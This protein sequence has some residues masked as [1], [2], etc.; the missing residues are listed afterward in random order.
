VSNTVR[1]DAVLL[2]TLALL[3]LL[4]QAPTAA[5]GTVTTGS[6]L[7]GTVTEAGGRTPIA[8]AQVRLVPSRPTPGVMPLMQM[9]SVITDREGRF[10]FEGVAAGRYRF[11]VQ[12]AG[13][14]TVDASREITLADGERKTDVTLSLQRGGAIAGRVLDNSGEPV[15]N[16]NVIA[17]RHPPGLPASAVQLQ[18]ILVPAGNSAQTNDL[19]EFR[20]FGLPPGEYALQV[21]SRDM[22]GPAA[23]ARRSTPVATYYPG[24]TDPIAAQMITVTAGQTLPNVDVGLI[25]LPAFQVSGVVHDRA[26]RPVMNALIR[27]TSADESRG[28]LAMMM[29]RINQAHTDA[30]GR[31]TMNSLTA[32]TYALV[33]MAPVVTSGAR[34]GRSGGASPVDFSRGGFITGVVAGS[35]GGGVTTETRGDGTTT[36]WREDT[37]TRTAVTISEADV[38]GL[39]IVISPQ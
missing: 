12:K 9:P 7:S 11:D 3:S 21:S 24:T 22:Y 2:I 10:T 16:A 38:T 19:G 17:L 15:A 23:P 26:G 8:G 18:N 25:E 34:S 28:P 14:A 39:E 27:L 13:F 30:S 20:L 35:S 36:E 37:A 4:A 32:G 33:A 6:L 5:P 31:F 29:S 1:S